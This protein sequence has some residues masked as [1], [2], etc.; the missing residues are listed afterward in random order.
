MWK[1]AEPND[2]KVA[3]GQQFMRAD[4][5]YPI[6]YRVIDTF[7]TSTGIEHVR[8]QKGDYRTDVVA[9]AKSALFDKTNYIEA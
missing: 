4:A 2:R 1:A 3:I 6:K 7:F 5:S 9:V 8:L